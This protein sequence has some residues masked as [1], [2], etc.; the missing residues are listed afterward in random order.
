M[1]QG[2]QGMAQALEASGCTPL[3]IS[4]LTDMENPPLEWYISSGIIMLHHIRK[5]DTMERAIQVIKLRGVRHSEQIYPI[6]LNEKG[7]HVLH[8]RLMP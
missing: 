3:L 7:L 1:R 2:L 8:P 4:E 5:D 6:R